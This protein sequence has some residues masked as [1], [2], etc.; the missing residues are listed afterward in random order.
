MERT[1]VL[2]PTLRSHFEILYKRQ[3]LFGKSPATCRLYGYSFKYFDDHLG[4]E[5]TIHDLTDENVMGTMEMIRGRGLS[6]RTANKTRD[7]L[8][9]L[10]SFLARK[11]IVPTWP[12][13][14][15]FPEPHRD[16]VAWSRAELFALWEV[17]AAQMGTIAGIPAGRWWLSLHALAWDTLERVGALRQLLWSDVS[18][19][20][21]WVHIRAEIRKGRRRDHTAKL[22]PNTGALLRSIREPAREMVFPWDKNHVYFWTRY[23]RMRAS[24]GLSVDRLHSF[25][26]LRRTGASFAEAAGVDAS[27]LLGHSS[28]K[29]TERYYLSSRIV[30]RPQA[31]DNLF[32]PDD[33]RDPNRAA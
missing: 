16:P 18:I 31:A 21:D 8:C 6:L 23:K 10:W 7:Q 11:G 17:C 33:D 25:H 5:C 9:A 19:G 14:P 30:Q 4:R 20:M 2:T 15:S 12:E 32:R 3:R 13:V 27:V 1:T 22:H 24:V 28:R 29:V 26:A